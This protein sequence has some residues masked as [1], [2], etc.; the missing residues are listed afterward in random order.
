MDKIVLIHGDVTLYEATEIPKTAKKINWIPGFIMEKGEGVHT[1]TIENDCD[2]Y[3][4]EISG[5]MYFKEKSEKIKVNHEEHGLKEINTDTKI[6][7][8]DLEQEFDYESMEA[9]NTQD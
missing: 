6:V 4:D 7:Y 5:R 3:V 1:H 2:I 8:K 9:R